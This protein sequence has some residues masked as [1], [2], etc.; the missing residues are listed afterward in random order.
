[1]KKKLCWGLGSCWGQSEMACCNVTE[2]QL[3]HLLWRGWHPWA[4][5]PCALSQMW[6]WYRPTALSA[7]QGTRLQGDGVIV[8]S[9]ELMGLETQRRGQGK[10]TIGR[11]GRR[12]PGH[13][14]S[15]IGPRPIIR[16]IKQL[17]SPWFEPGPAVTQ[18]PAHWLRA[19]P[20]YFSMER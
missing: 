3:G 13:L 18:Y 20:S 16:G 12:S 7:R 9:A 5:N 10:A 11:K 17:P 14:Q 1:M 6:R 15:S 2:N 4:A 19:V 8:F